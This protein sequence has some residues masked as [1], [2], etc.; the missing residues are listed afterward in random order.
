MGRSL[1]MILV[2]VAQEAESSFMGEWSRSVAPYA[3][4]A[5]MGGPPVANSPVIAMMGVGGVGAGAASCSL[6]PSHLEAMSPSL[7]GSVHG[8][9]SLAK[10]GAFSPSN[11]KHSY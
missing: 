9:P 8:L 3:H 6:I 4:L 10:M 2:V 5:G 1:S 7:E 11:C